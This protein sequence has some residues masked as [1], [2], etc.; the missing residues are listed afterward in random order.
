[1][2]TQKIRCPLIKQPNHGSLQNS[3][4]NKIKMWI[5]VER[6]NM[7]KWR[8]IKEN[9]NVNYYK[10]KCWRVQRGDDNFVGE[11]MDIN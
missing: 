11:W 1:M 2:N 6:K 7:K 3:K 4:S 9:K 8:K 10:M 5:A